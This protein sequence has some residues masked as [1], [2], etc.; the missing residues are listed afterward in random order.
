MLFFLRDDVL[1]HLPHQTTYDEQLIRDL[2]LKSNAS[3]NVHA[4]QILQRTIASFDLKTK[5][6]VVYEEI[7]QAMVHVN[8]NNVCKPILRRIEGNDTQRSIAQQRIAGAIA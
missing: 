5:C 6:K 3:V 8:V 2:S 7:E 4:M 1:S